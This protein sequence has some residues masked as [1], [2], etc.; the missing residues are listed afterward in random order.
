MEIIPGWCCCPLR[1]CGLG[2]GIPLGRDRH[3]AVFSVRSAHNH[4]EMTI[5]S[6]AA[7]SINLNPE[8][9]L[10]SLGSLQCHLKCPSMFLDIR[11]CFQNPNLKRIELVPRRMGTDV[12]N[13]FRIEHVT[14]TE[15]LVFRTSRQRTSLGTAFLD[16]HILTLDFGPA[17]SC[18]LIMEGCNDRFRRSNRNAMLIQEFMFEE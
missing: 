13:K 5:T 1:V 3:R 6:G 10:F 15:H 9:P 4:H 7:I 18:F 12:K 17:V 8:Y 14:G 16:G 2:F 11:H